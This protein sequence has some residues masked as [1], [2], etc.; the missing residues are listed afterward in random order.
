MPSTLA[1]DENNAKITE[2]FTTGYFPDPK[3]NNRL[4][5]RRTKN[6]QFI[7]EETRENETS[8][9][10]KK[11]TSKRNNVN[12]A[13]NKKL[14]LQKKEEEKNKNIPPKSETNVTAIF[15]HAKQIPDKKPKQSKQMKT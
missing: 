9:N 11:T 1:I 10:T 12:S 5:T 3:I 13:W 15:K 14:N 7:Y 6:T 2:M 8:G 4:P